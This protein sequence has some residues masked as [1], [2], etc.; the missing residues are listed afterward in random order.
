M[1]ICRR[2]GQRLAFRHV[3]Q[4]LPCGKVLTV[5]TSTSKRSLA[6]CDVAGESTFGRL[7]R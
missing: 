6:T 5:V 1:E 7:R 4:P 2:D 3:K